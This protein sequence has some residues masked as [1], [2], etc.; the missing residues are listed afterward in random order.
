MCP[1]VFHHNHNNLCYKLY[2]YKTYV[3]I[4]VKLHCSALKM[5]TTVSIN[6]VIEYMVCNANAQMHI[7][8]IYT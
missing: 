7:M 8:F 5:A 6:N 1:Y 4:Y 3:R 2:V